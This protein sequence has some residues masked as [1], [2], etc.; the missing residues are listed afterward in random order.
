MRIQGFDYF[1][2]IQ[3]NN[4]TGS[5]AKENQ[6]RHS[7]DFKT[8]GCQSWGGKKRGKKKLVLKPA[9]STLVPKKPPSVHHQSQ[10][11]E[12][13]ATGRTVT[14]P[15]FHDSH[16]A[17]MLSLHPEPGH[18]VLMLLICLMSPSLSV[19]HTHLYRHMG[20]TVKEIMIGHA[21]QH[22]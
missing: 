5:P 2:L 20:N 9:I 12:L 13:P 11:K 8:Q 22:L 19:S 4:R 21:F 15:P 10:V 3:R 17:A 18:L 7:S 14:D 1:T 6:K 16:P